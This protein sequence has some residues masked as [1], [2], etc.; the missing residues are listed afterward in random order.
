MRQRQPCERW[1]CDNGPLHHL[2]T[3]VAQIIGLPGL[4]QSP[5]RAFRT[6]MTATDGE[7]TV[8]ESGIG[9]GSSEVVYNLA[10]AL[11]RNLK[12]LTLHGRKVWKIRYRSV[13]L[14]H[15]RDTTAASKDWDLT[16]PVDGPTTNVQ[17]FRTSQGQFENLADL[18]QQIRFGTVCDQLRRMT[19]FP[20]LWFG[21]LRQV[22]RRC[23]ED[24]LSEVRVLTDIGA[25]EVTGRPRHLT[26]TLLQV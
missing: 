5:T 18:H 11:T 23:A 1:Q 15:C 24:W 22:G 17:G 25:F 12:F 8:S 26:A 3:Q 6:V 4:R 10:P 21:F 14:S 19:S 16:R 9:S 7:G 20:A 13:C 2:S